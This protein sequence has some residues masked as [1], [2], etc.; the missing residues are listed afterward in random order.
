MLDTEDFKHCVKTYV[1]L[2]DEIA[3]SGKHLSEL[4]KKKEAIGELIMEFMKHKGID[5]CE[6][7]DNGG[8]LVRKE[9]KRTE[10]LKKEHIM[11]ELMALVNQD[12]TRAE[13]VL[14]NIYGKRNVE[15]T[16][17]LTRTKR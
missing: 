10:T 3:S 12:N 17:R 13:N 9:S 14:N 2:H 15:V 6:L 11:Q 8:K 7:Q 4:R 5:E 16:E 1:E